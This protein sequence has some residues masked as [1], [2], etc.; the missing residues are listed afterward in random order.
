LNITGTEFN[1][2][3]N[4]FNKLDPKIK[5]KATM[6]QHLRD[7]QKEGS[8]KNSKASAVFRKNSDSVPGRGLSIKKQRSP[9]QSKFA[10]HRSLKNN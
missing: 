4:Y 3:G 2:S 6:D 9:N 1:V 10:S 7:T 5:T 8:T